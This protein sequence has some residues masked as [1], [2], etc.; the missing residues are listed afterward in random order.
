M[1]VDGRIK[2]YK[3]VA[4]SAVT[5]SAVAVLSICVTLPM[6]YDYVHQVRRQVHS[7]VTYCKVHSTCYIIAYLL[8]FTYFDVF[9]YSC[10]SLLSINPSNISTGYIILLK[11][12]FTE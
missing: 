4:Y 7:E 2:A 5:F 6:V 11:Y 12:Y 3:F 9:T 1:D 8:L 10:I